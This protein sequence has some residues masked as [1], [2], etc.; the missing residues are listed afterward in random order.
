MSCT[1]YT[2]YAKLKDPPFLENMHA[3][4]VHSATSHYLCPMCLV[5]CNV[6]LGN[7]QFM[8]TFIVFRSLCQGTHVLIHS[9]DTIMDE[10]HL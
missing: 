10:L 3:L 8:H 1:S 2:C 6:M 4:S 5:H 7:A 9:V